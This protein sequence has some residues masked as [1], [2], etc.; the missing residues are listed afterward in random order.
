[1]GR[2]PGT[3]RRELLFGQGVHARGRCFE[4]NLMA[5]HG[6]EVE[7]GPRDDLGRRPPRED[8]ETKATQQGRGTDVDPHHSKLAIPP[9]ELDVRDPRQPP[10]AK[11]KDLR[12]EDVAREQELV[13]GKLV[14]DRIGRDHDL[15]RERSDRRPRNPAAAT[16]DAHA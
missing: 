13:A 12:V 6:C 4:L 10:P 2:K 14:L 9:H 11:I 1:M 16:P 5:T 8:T 3:K 7:L 15:F